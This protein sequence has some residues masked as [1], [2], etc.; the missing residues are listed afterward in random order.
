[1]Y[2]GKRGA[3]DATCTTGAK[4]RTLHGVYN[5]IKRLHAT[6]LP[7]SLYEYKT[8]QKRNTYD[9]NIKIIQVKSSN[10]IIKA[11]LMRR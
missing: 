9:N 6:R 2:I 5:N 8:K 10:G 11:L 4:R 1:M 3:C 7:C